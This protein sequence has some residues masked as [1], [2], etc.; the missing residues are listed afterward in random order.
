MQKTVRIQDPDPGKSYTVPKGFAA[1]QD[2][3][4]WRRNKEAVPAPASALTYGSI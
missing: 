2:T 3:I 4:L 1:L